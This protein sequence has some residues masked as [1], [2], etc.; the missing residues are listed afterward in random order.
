VEDSPVYALVLQ[1]AFES[2]G[3]SATLAETVTGAR[4]LL[5]ASVAGLGDTVPAFD[6]VLSDVNLADGPAEDL[7]S[8]L[9]AQTRPGTVLPPVYCMTAQID[10][11]LHTRAAV[12]RSPMRK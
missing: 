9:N 2:Q 3:V 7:L 6:L 12:W 8:Q 4:D 5:A 11:F 1:Q 10:A